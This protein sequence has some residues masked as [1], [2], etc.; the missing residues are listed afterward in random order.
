MVLPHYWCHQNANTSW[1]TAPRKYPTNSSRLIRPFLV[2]P[3]PTNHL[4][5]QPT[6]PNQP[7]P[8]NQTPN[9][10][11]EFLSLLFF[12]KV[13]IHGVIRFLAL[14]SFLQ[15]RHQPTRATNQPWLATR[16]TMVSNQHQPTA[17]WLTS[18]AN[19]TCSLRFRI[20]AY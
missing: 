14:P 9:L 19:Q 18:P 6:K 20:L 2:A 3:K 1:L 7:E 12:P 4:T 13:A 17:I 5:N 10:V 8:T 11:Y 15:P 16:P